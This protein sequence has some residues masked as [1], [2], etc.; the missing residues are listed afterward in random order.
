V[1]DVEKDQTELD[2]MDQL[3]REKPEVLEDSK[4]FVQHLQMLFDRY[5]QGGVLGIPQQGAYER[6]S[7]ENSSRV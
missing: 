7:S 2:L 3:S 4:S 5:K 1:F 6:V